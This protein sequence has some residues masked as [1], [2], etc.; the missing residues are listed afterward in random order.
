MAMSSRHGSIR[1]PDVA[2]VSGQCLVQRSHQLGAGAFERA[3]AVLGER[4]EA[5]VAGRRDERARRAR[6][7]RVDNAEA[8][9]V[10]RDQLTAA[11][12]AA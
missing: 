7:Q 4:F 5:G 9:V 3:P 2:P 6:Q 8:L 11:R 12:A 1:W 10:M